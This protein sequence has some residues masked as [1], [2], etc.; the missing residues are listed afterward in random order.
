MCAVPR[1]GQHFAEK[2]PFLFGELV[3]RF[4]R[5][6]KAQAVGYCV[7]YIVNLTTYVVRVE[8]LAPFGRIPETLMTQAE[9][10]T[11]GKRR[12]TIHE[13]LERHRG[14]RVCGPEVNHIDANRT[15]NS[16]DNLEWVT[17]GQNIRHSYKMQNRSAVGVNNANVTI[18]ED[19][20]KEICE[21]LQKGFKSSKIRDLGYPYNI[22]RQI[23]SKAIWIHI[24]SNYNF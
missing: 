16:L 23:K 14:E 22:V 20:V 21:L 8:R 1:S 4:D 18:T 19:T 10:R 17:H 3:G 11:R 12:V 15:N 2:L 5:F 9:M 6:E 7:R 13:R 24:S